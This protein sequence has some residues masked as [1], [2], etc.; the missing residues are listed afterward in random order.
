MLSG[1]W[2]EFIFISFPPIGIFVLAVLFDWARF[3]NQRWGWVRSRMGGMEGSW[4]V[5]ALIVD[6]TGAVARL[7]Y[8]AFTVS[9]AYDFGIVSAGILAITVSL[10]GFLP[11][12]P[13]KDRPEIWIIATILI[14]IFGVG[15]FFQVTW[16][17]MISPHV[18]SGRARVLD[19]DTVV[20]NRQTIRLNATCP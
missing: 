7:F 3:E 12:V 6:A 14:W 1:D 10:F 18:V 15:L 9:V 19:G 16:F 5:L 17:G 4:E 13:F 2:R 8:Y 20:V 11:I